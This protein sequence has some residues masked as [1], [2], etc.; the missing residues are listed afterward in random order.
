[1]TSDLDVLR[2]LINDGAL[3]Q[4]SGEPGHGRRPAKLE[5]T[6]NDTDE[7]RYSIWIKGIPD[8]AVI[9]KTDAFP[10][11]KSIFK[12][13]RGECKRADYVIVASTGSKNYIVYMEMKKGRGDR[14][15]IVDQLKGSECF[16]SYCRAIAGRFWNRPNFLDSNSCESRFVSITKIGISKSPTRPRGSAGLHDAPEKMMRIDYVGD[17]GGVH[18]SKL[19]RG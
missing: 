9:I 16:V 18:F 3:V 7:N 6:G 15:N 17:G 19:I 8:D 2:E 11:P 10:A 13:G 4:L 12:C 5:E 1:M 14:G